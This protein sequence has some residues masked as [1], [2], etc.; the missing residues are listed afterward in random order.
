MNGSLLREPL[1][2][3]LV[4]GAA[5]FGLFGLVGRKHAEAPAKIV[6]S[7]PRVATLVDGFART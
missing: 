1:L 4:L 7:A 6:V 2:H 3:F 5:L